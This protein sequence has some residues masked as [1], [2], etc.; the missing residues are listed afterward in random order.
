LALL[1]DQHQGIVVLDLDDTDDLA[2]AIARLDIDDAD[3]ATRLDAILVQGRA[4]A[5]ALL[6]D[7]QDRTGRAEHLHGDNRVLVAE[8]HAADTVGA[9]TRRAHVAFR[10]PDGHAVARCD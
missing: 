2:I 3:A 9:A 7:G 4:L 1:R 10:K 6:G 5:V 8:R